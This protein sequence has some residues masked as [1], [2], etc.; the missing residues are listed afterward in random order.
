[1][2]RVRKPWPPS[3]HGLMTPK[4]SVTIWTERHGAAG[5]RFDGYAQLGVHLFHS[6]KAHLTRVE[7]LIDALGKVQS[8]LAG[9]AVRYGDADSFGEETVMG[10]IARAQRTRERSAARDR[11]KHART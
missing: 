1:M 2:G 11:R 3:K 5:V 10:P 6:E 9:V 4:S 8:H 7:A